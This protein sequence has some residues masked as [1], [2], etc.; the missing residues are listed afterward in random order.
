MHVH[1]VL[2]IELCHRCLVK[3]REWQSMQISQKVAKR[4]QQRERSSERK[5]EPQT[6]WV[7]QKRLPSS[8]IHS[9]N[10]LHH[11][12]WVA[13]LE[14]HMEGECRSL[15]FFE[16]LPICLLQKNCPAQQDV[17]LCAHHPW[18]PGPLLL[19]RPKVHS[20]GLKNGIWSGDGITL[21]FLLILPLCDN[22]RGKKYES[23]VNT[24]SS[25]TN[26]SVI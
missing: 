11:A 19:A 9:L 1:I 25:H 14:Q 6:H 2:G 18:A 17:A 5:K 10:P 16:L 20:L 4:E 12:V 21:T 23:T 24:A 15:E 22:G 26:G 13:D 3:G 8:P 7:S